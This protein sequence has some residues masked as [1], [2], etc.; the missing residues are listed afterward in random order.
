MSNVEKPL[1]IDIPVKLSDLKVVFSVAALAFEG[2]LAASIFHLQLITNNIAD[3]KAKAQ[4]I[5]VFH[6]LAGHATGNHYGMGL[7][8]RPV[9][10]TLLRQENQTTLEIAQLAGIAERKG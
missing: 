8:G 5:A 9:I 2:D 3:W 4:V 6:T 1:H 7:T 10:T